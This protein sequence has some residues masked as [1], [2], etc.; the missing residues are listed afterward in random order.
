MA[1]KILEDVNNLV[2]ESELIFLI[3]FLKNWQTLKF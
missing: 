1:H 3:N 2:N